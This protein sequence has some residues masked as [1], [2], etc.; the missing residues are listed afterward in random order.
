MTNKLEDI[1]RLSVSERIMMV[2]AIWDS[3]PEKEGTLELSDET[4][5]LIDDRLANHL[6][7]PN[8]GSTWEE[9]KSRIK[10]QF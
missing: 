7:N 2:E 10:T 5:K 3:I 8:E 4:K 9:V 1:L 6:N